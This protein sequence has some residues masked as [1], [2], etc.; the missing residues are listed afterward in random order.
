VLRAVLTAPRRFA[1]ETAP[2]PEV[3]ERDVLIQVA[4]CGVCTGEIELW[5]NEELSGH[6]FRPGHE[7]AGRVVA[8][9]AGVKEVRPG[10]L[11]AA[12]TGAGFAKFTRADVAH[13]VRLPP[14]VQLED[15]I[16][17]PLA[18][19]VNAARRVRPD[20]QDTIVL[21]GCGFMGLL[22]LQCLKARSPKLIIAVDV[23]Q[24]AVDRAKAFGADLGLCTGADDVRQAVME[25]T[26]GK[27]ADIVIEATGTQGGL[28]LCGELVR[29]RGHLVIFGYHQSGLRQVDMKRWNYYG[30]DVTNAHERDPLV[31]AAGMR[32]GLDLV[33][34][35]K[36]R[37]PELITHRYPL[38]QIQEAFE[39]AH[40]K[41]AGY[42]K[43]TVDPE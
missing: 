39:L 11:V 12:I 14:G 21:V 43:A 41:P 1:I 23:R 9:G 3:G 35:G 37:L 42:V 22:L 40:S 32:A 28:T 19:A 2:M 25:L 17:E 36:V 16:G 18:C 34:Q 7:A 38:R 30:L 4:T 27:G 20:Y 31:Y 29:I 8:V 5:A 15:A 33:A 24:E 13:V 26:E 6:P 10:D